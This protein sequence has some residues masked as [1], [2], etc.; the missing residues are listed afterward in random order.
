[1]LT[2]SE[3]TKRYRERKL[4]AAELLPKVPCLCG[5]GRMLRALDTN[6]RPARYAHG[7]NPAPSHTLFNAER[8]ATFNRAR[9]GVPLLALRG[10][11]RPAE[12]IARR[13]VA[14]LRNNGGV[15]Q[16]KHGWKHAPETIAKMTAA[17]RKRDL[18]GANNPFYGRRHPPEVLRRIA[19][20]NS[21]PNSPHWRGGVST[22]PY[23]PEFTRKFKRSILE[24]DGHY[25]RRCGNHQGELKRKLQVHHLDHDK[26]NN[27][28]GNLAASCCSCNIWASYHREQPFTLSPPLA[29]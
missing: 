23:G 15:Y 16:T 3:I 9:T 19:E 21:G 24:R 14:R 7:H 10:R 29:R 28:P 18:A 13:Q 12:E 5:C 4:A 1:M 17:V 2:R 20:K 22:L 25:C 6:L 26:K 27:D 8:V 11:K